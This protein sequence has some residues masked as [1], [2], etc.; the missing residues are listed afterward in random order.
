[1]GLALVSGPLD[2]TAA[3][4]LPYGGSISFLGV[5]LSL[6]VG[7]GGFPVPHF[8]PP[9]TLHLQDPSEVS[10]KGA[11]LQVFSEALLKIHWLPFVRDVAHLVL[12]CAV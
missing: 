12:G 1:M 8:A 10:E 2:M 3:L 5:L 11:G 4:D 9:V 7:R 6:E